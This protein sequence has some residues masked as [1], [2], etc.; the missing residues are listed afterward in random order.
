MACP[1]TS[2]L[3][4][5]ALLGTLVA[6]GS[7]Q[8]FAQPPE[9]PAPAPVAGTPWMAIGVDFLGA[10]PRGDFS[11]AASAAYGVN[12]QFHYHLTP[13]L[14]VRVEGGFLEY[15][16]ESREVCLPTCRVL[17]DMTTTNNIYFG[18]VGVEVVRP[19]GSIRPYV[20]LGLGG[21][22][23][24]TET[25]LEGVDDE[26]SIGNT[27]NFDDNTS[28]VSIG[29]GVYIPVQRS[30]GL[31]TI[32]LG[33]RFH[34]NDTVRYLREGDIEDNADGSISFTPTRSR[35]NLVAIVAGVTFNIQRRR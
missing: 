18:S 11:N 4:A 24:Q 1:H 22:S 9:S 26:D 19:R 35:A 32:D 20:N 5:A 14:R 27:T 33:V 3:V 23:F 13:M 28:L 16:R 29:G 34:H 30:G 8:A 2:R 7:T 6:A 17:F 12:A 15:G 10:A 21:S 25:H 31:L